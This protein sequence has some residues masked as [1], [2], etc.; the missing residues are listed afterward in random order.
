MAIIFVR[1]QIVQCFVGT[2]VVVGMLPRFELPVQLRGD[3]DDAADDRNASGHDAD[4]YGR[5]P[6]SQSFGL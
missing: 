5:A 3:V 2:D 6:L 1:R 4:I